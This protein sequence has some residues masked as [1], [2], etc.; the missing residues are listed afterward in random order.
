[1]SLTVLE[2]ALI[3]GTRVGSMILNGPKGTKL[4]KFDIGDKYQNKLIRRNLLKTGE[5]Y[6]SFTFSEY[7][8][9][10]QNGL[11]DDLGKKVLIRKK[12]LDFKAKKSLMKLYSM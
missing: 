8:S 6:N 12:K 9:R 11:N 4:Q 1:M 10:I 5:D 2:I 7:I 3:D